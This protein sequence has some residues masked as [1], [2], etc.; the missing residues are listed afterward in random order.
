M[1]VSAG[2]LMLLN[3]L[4]LGA[5]LGFFATRVLGAMLD[6][7]SQRDILSD[8][9]YCACGAVVGLVL[10][11]GVIYEAD[12]S[13]ATHYAAFARYIHPFAGAVIV[14]TFHRLARWAARKVHEGPRVPK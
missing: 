1:F 9:V 8:I 5:V 6:F 2:L 7:R 12:P 13:P 4:C 11:F 10:L 14:G 3:V